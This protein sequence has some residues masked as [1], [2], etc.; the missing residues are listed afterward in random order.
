MKY[1]MDKIHIV[2]ILPI[3]NIVWKIWEGQLKDEQ[4]IIYFRDVT[5]LSVG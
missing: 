2:K 4:E 5:V 1:Y 3:E